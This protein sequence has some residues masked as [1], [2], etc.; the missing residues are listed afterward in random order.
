MKIAIIGSGISG[1]AAAWLLHKDHDIT[2][3]EQNDKAGGHANTVSLPGHPAVDTGFIVYNE[4]TYP[5]LIALFD[6]LGVA[7]E[8]TDMS[9]AVSLREG[10]LEYAGD[11]LFAQKKNIVNLRFY[12]MIADII[13]FYRTA[14]EILVKP[15]DSQAQET[16]GEYLKRKHYS[17]AFIE[18][19]ILPM[20][21]AI[22]STSAKDTRDFPLRSFV[23]FFV[24]HG[25]FLFR[26]RPQWYTVTGGSHQYVDKLTAPFAERIRTNTAVTNA[27]R[28]QS[29]IM[30]TLSD[31]QTEIFD[32]VIFACH[33]DQ[34]LA[35]IDRP[36]KAETDVL[37][38][39]PYAENTAYF[40][41]DPAMMPK[42]RKAWAS[43]N[44]LTAE[45][46]HHH[47]CVTYWMNRLQP[48]LPK[49]PNYFVTLNPPRPPQKDKILQTIRYH[50]PQYTKSALKGWE[51]IQNIQG[52][53]RFWF[54]G[55]WCGFGFHEDGLSAGLAVAEAL[56]GIKRPWDVTEKSPAGQHAWPEP[57]AA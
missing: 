45:K 56:S 19:H 28:S 46:D 33:A 10:A 7:T 30:L 1:N 40:H 14:P 39:F 22:W 26:D 15:L 6:H 17:R 49:E 42:N 44:Y 21:A 23:Q 11:A 20:A 54:C 43:W 36:T 31:G 51:S 32:Q 34:A 38:A 29:G 4:A 12:R 3:F 41:T 24:N 47:I 9:F 2:V 52:K 25:L 8:R 27:R 37:S 5:N 16:L 48:F 50:H 53:D 18:D 13:R 55:A 35:I 57:L